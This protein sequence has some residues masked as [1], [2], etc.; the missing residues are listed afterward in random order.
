MSEKGFHVSTTR[1]LLAFAAAIVI[2]LTAIVVIS[3]SPA[4]GPPVALAGPC[5]ADPLLWFS[6][7]PP[8]APPRSAI[9]LFG[10]PGG[11]YATSLDVGTLPPQLPEGKDPVTIGINEIAGHEGTSS[12]F[13]PAQ[14]G[15]SFTTELLFVIGQDVP[16][17]IYDYEIEIYCHERTTFVPFAV[18]VDTC[19][20]PSS[21]GFN[22]A[23]VATPS[24]EPFPDTCDEP[25]PTLTPPP[26]TDTPT[27][28]PSPPPG[29]EVTWADN[30]CSSS[31]D[32]VDSLFVLRADA[33]LSANTGDCP[34]MGAG[35]NILN[36]SLHIWGD[37]DCTGSMTPVD[38]LKI[39]R[40]DA[41]LS[42][43]QAAS[44]PGMG[45]QV[46]LAQQ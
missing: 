43:S 15:G 12:A 16:A 38:S 14:S 45:T 9:V 23:G 3:Y 11:R 30:N 17:G 4:G 44:C 39:L 20:A 32:P 8:G 5:G 13:T 40:F 42:V 34:A 35:I 25:A 18:F 24:P 27:P 1:S 46:T 37:V 19:P 22:A 29:Q 36:A 31:V 2:A 33:G 26:G 7:D 10:S 6:S 41:G 21:A 28:T